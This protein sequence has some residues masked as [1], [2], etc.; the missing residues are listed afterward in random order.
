[1]AS[2]P[3]TDD[4]AVFGLSDLHALRE[5]YEERIARIEREREVTVDVL[6][7]DAEARITADAR[8]RQELIEDLTIE[9]A[10]AREEG[11]RRA[12]D[13]DK[14]RVLAEDKL[15]A[16]LHDVVRLESECARIRS[17]ISALVSKASDVMPLPIAQPAVKPASLP[18]APAF[19][20]AEK[21]RRIRLR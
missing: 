17:A 4:G 20:A 5:Q 21:R 11:E 6:K 1:M 10:A 13:A 8:A 9:L 2:E 14:R 3:T 18:A 7:R 12:L 15:V 19:G 16:V